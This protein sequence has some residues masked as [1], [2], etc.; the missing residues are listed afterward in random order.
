[1]IY[2]V[3]IGL[4]LS[5]ICYY[6][7]YEKLYIDHYFLEVEDNG[8]TDSFPNRNFDQA[9]K[10]VLKASEFIFLYITLNSILLNMSLCDD[11]MRM[12]KSPFINANTRLLVYYAISFTLPFFLVLG[13]YIYADQDCPTILLHSETLSIQ[14]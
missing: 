3:Y 10:F 11:L 13:V 7:C 9:V 2:T 4:L 5:P 6:W 14:D 1:M 12:L 8:K